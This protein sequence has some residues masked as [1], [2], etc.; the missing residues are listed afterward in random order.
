MLSDA[1][2]ED[3]DVNVA[4]M[5]A[6]IADPCS[7][8][9]SVQFTASGKVTVPGGSSGDPSLAFLKLPAGFCVHYFATVPNARQLRFAPGGELFVASPSA[10]TTG[11]NSA[12]ALDAIV[13]LPDDNHDGV[14]D[15]PLTFVQF[16]SGS[17]T[18]GLLFTPGFFYFQ[19][20]TPPG[21]K[22]MRVPYAAGNREPSAPA[23]QVADINVYTSSL[24]WPKTM[25]LADDGTIYVGNGGD[26]GESCVSS[27]PFRGGILKI[28]PSPDGGHPNGV[29][30]AQGM[31]NPINVKCA[32]GHNRCFALEFLC[33][34]TS[35]AQGGRQAIIPIDQGDDW[36]FPCC[37]TKNTPYTGNPDRQ[38]LGRHRRDQ[39]VPHRRHAVRHRVRA[40]QVAVDVGRTRVR[41]HT[42]SGRELERNPDGVHP[43]GR[44]HGAPHGEHRHLRQH[45]RAQ[46]RDGRLRDGLGRRNIRARKTG[47]AG[48][49][50]RRTALRRQRQQWRDLLDRAAE[51]VKRGPLMS[52]E[53]FAPQ[54]PPEPL[55][56]ERLES[57]SKGMV[58]LVFRA[59]VPGGY[60]VAT[61]WGTNP[62]QTTFVP[63]ERAWNVKL[64]TA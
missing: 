3:H 54:S 19:D 49:R 24:H 29:E 7:L 8:P 20:G 6:A 60:L 31:R 59:R 44:D 56:W 43:D 55:T 27:H 53:V 25:D 52:D 23:E 39:L 46:R 15:A 18:Q 12:G 26:Q 62:F 16:A 57:T 48:L 45:G 47:G 50:T 37:A 22:I 58:P 10:S 5:D 61:Q 33:S 11:G 17:M 28:D 34:T 42:R 9:G 63:S 40:R 14:G 51:P 21:T 4:P 30:V 1:S 36:G 13:L 32:Q 2:L 41:R 35:A 38:L 64:H